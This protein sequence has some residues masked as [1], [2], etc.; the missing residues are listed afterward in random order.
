VVR[1]DRS[2]LLAFA[3]EL[4]SRDA[5]LAA[6]LDR[7]QA[8]SA[9]LEEIRSALRGTTETLR[10]VPRELAHA[11]RATAEADGLLAVARRE[12]EPA[13]GAAGGHRE[14]DALAERVTHLTALIEELR[15]E[16]RTATER[17]D[18][19]DVEAALLAEELA[20][21][22][23]VGDLPA[24]FEWA[25]STLLVTRTT[26]EAE[27]DLIVREAAELLTSALGEPVGP[28]SVG[29]LRQRLQR[30]LA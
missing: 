23:E 28:G 21:G 1:A 16:E 22:S 11:E 20:S 17:R 19:I 13:H 9:R 15:A 26:L 29:R 12:Y 5:A 7:L 25:Q 8:L 14:A 3:E 6:E 10:R 4:E 30:E 27:R 2:D 24:W 18:A